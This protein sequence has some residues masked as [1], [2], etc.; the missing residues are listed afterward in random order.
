MKPK[1]SRHSPWHSSGWPGL[2][3]RK[4]KSMSSR[5]CPTYGSLAR[6]IGGDKVD[7]T[8][9]AKPTEDPHFV[10]ARPSFVVK[11]RQADVLDRR[12]RGARDRLAA[13]APAKRAQPEDRSRPTRARAG[14]ARDSADGGAGA[15]DRARPATCT[16]WAIR[17]SWSIP[18]S[19]KPSRNIS[20][21]L[22]LR[23]IQRTPPTTR[24]TTR[25]LKQRSTPS[26]RNGERS[27][28][29]SKGRASSLI[30]IRGLISRTVLGLTSTFFSS[31]SRAFHRRPRILR[32]SSSR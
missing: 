20:Q 14:V 2:S 24:R 31:R 32:R 28:C 23:P 3:R 21:T 10:D 4:P 29:P 12:R 18:S 5:L 22:S 1:S 16:R 13:A 19:R 17:I 7:V 15:I 25:N 11:L 26:F 9:L 27:C 8:V 30:T 6:E